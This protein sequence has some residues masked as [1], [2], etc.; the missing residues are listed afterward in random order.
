MII[1]VWGYTSIPL[2]NQPEFCFPSSRKL[3]GFT[4]LAPWD[5]RLVSQPSPTPTMSSTGTLEPCFP[6]V[7]SQL[8]PKCLPIVSLLSPN[9]VQLSPTCL[10]LSPICLPIVSHCVSIVSPLPIVPLLSKS[11]PLVSLSIVSRLCFNCLPLVSHLY[12]SSQQQKAV[13]FQF[14]EF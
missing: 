1:T 13:W 7:F 11:L 6:A 5:A 8:S 14:L 2:I 9:C 10:H 4:L 12:P 3:L